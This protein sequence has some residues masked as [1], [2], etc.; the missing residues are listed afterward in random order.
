MN[1][2]GVD[3]HITGMVTK[4]FLLTH[5]L[6]TLEILSIGFSVCSHVNIPYAY[7]IELA[8]VQKSNTK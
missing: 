7:G 3:T 2:E 6:A 8:H 4:Y 1:Q 5:C